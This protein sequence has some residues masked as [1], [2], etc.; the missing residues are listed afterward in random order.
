[1]GFEMSG[2]YVVFY[3]SVPFKA[4]SHN[5]MVIN[6]LVMQCFFFTN[7]NGFNNAIITNV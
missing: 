1:M 6:R 5:F 4:V 3:C 2:K 7:Q